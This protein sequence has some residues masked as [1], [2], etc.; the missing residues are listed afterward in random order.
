MF[1]IAQVDG[2]WIKANLGGFVGV[3]VAMIILPVAYTYFWLAAYTLKNEIKATKVHWEQ[4]EM[5]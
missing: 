4:M 1:G 5:H 3:V 2:P